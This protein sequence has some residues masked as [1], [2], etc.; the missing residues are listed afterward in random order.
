MKIKTLFTLIFIAG[1]SI[2]VFAQDSDFEPSE[3]RSD[4]DQRKVSIMDGNRL[5][6]LIACHH[7]SA[8]VVPPVIRDACEL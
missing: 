3:E 5:W 2:P 1:I 6:G 4:F 7:N 8:K